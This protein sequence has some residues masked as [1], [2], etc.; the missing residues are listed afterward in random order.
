MQVMKRLYATLAVLVALGVMSLC[1]AAPSL[2]NFNCTGVW[3]AEHTFSDIE[4]HVN[5]NGEYIEGVVYVY[6]IFGGKDTYHYQ[7]HI[8][9]DGRVVAS[10]H[11]GHE[12]E[13]QMY[14]DSRGEGVVTTAKRK[15]RIHFEAIRRP[16]EEPESE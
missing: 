9:P 5:Q 15:I 11:S 10:H 14:S 16:G 3:D 2:A 1:C 12:F 6:G 8:Y 7:G 13:G 4:I